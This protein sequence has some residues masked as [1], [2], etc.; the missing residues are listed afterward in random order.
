MA[1]LGVSQGLVGQVEA[2]ASGAGSELTVVQR[3]PRGLTFGYVGT[4]PGRVVQDLARLPGVA[5]VSPLVLVPVAITRELVFLI[6]G[7]DPAGP[8]VS[9]LRIMAGRGLR[10]G[11]GGVLLL[12][13]RAAAGMG[14]GVGDL[15]SIDGRPLRVVGIYRSGISLQ[16]GGAIMTLDGARQLIGLGDRVSLV[17]VKVTDPR[18]VPAV[19]REIASRIHDGTVLTSQQFARDRLNLE[20]AVQAAWAVSAIALLLSVLA[21]ANTTAMA[22]LERTREIGVLLA[23]GWSR[24]RIVALVLAEAVVASGLGG[25]AGVG[26]GM[27]TL[28][29]LSHISRGL[30]VPNSASPALLLQALLLSIGVGLVGGLLPAWRASRLDPV[31]ALRSL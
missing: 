23:V 7:V 16:D 13:E 4:H 28:R 27:A 18:R 22:V 6:Y 31:E 30:P 3:F 21:V 5:R 12:G 24:A 15:L 9:S 25:L 14:T 19:E 8:D 10:S 1:L 20:A 11:D 29:L 17:R 26:V 2:L